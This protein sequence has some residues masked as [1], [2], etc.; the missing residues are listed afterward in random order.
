MAGH[1]GQTTGGGHVGHTGQILG[2]VSWIV[3]VLVRIKDVSFERSRV[4]VPLIILYRPLAI[5]DKAETVVV[6]WMTV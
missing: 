3:T 2:M 5:C 1:I 6:G 4:S